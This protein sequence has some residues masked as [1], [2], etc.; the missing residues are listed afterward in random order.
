MYNIAI[1]AAAD[2]ETCISFA[3]PRN[4]RISKRKI[5]IRI[6]AHLAMGGYGV[7]RRVQGVRT[8]DFF[9]KTMY[10]QHSPE[11]FQRCLR[12]YTKALASPV[13]STYSYSILHN[14]ISNRTGVNPHFLLH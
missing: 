3:F 6:E 1:G 4:R 2:R 5:C 9:I 7:V 12:K 10:Q 8:P 11:G 13:R 14:I